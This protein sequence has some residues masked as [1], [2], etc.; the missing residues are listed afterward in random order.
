MVKCSKLV[1]A[2]R[3]GRAEWQPATADKVAALATNN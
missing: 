2:S 3:E 1:L